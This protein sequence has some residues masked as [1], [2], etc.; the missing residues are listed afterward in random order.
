MRQVIEEIR[1]GNFN[2]D[3][4]SLDFSCPR[5]EMSLLA[6]TVEEGSFSVYGPEG[7]VTEG[8][9]VS[10]DLRMECMTQNFSGSED[11][12]LYRFDARGMEE[13]E[14]VK[15]AF[16]VISNQGEYYLPFSVVIEPKIITSSLGNIKNLFHFTN[17]AKSNWEEAVKLFYSKEFGAVFNG[18]DKQYY[19]A[20][21]GLSSSYGNEHNVEEFL[22]E[23]RKK[24]PVEYIPEETQIKIEDPL[25]MTRYALVI[26]RNG[27]GYTHLQIRT[28]GEFLQIEEDTVTDS[29]FLGNIYRLYYYVNHEK[30]HA[31]NNYGAIV[32]E[33]EHETIRIPV[34]VVQH[35]TARKTLGLHREKMRQTVSL[36]EYY[37]AFRLKKISTK[38]WLAETHKLLNRMSEM[39]DRDIAVKL[40]R[41]Q[42]LLTEERDNEAKWLIE[43]QEEQ[44][45]SMQEENPE[46]WCYYLYLTT[47]YSKDDQ[48]V[49]DVAAL[50]E[51]FYNRNR[52]NWRIAWLLMYLSEEY[53]K[54][55]S[56]KWLLLEELFQ[57][58]CSSPVI[59]IEAWHILCM[60]PAMLMKL[61]TFELQILLYAVKNDLMKDEIVL[62]IVYLAQKQKSF[63]DHLFRILKGC[64]EKKP[65]NDILHAICTLL[66]KGNCQGEEYFPWY[67]A[68]VEQNLRITRLYEYYMMSISLPYDG[69]LP[70]MILMY[71]AY[72][73]DL[74]YEITAY[75]Y[76]YVY[77]H[78]EEIPDIYVNYCAAM[79]RFVLEQIQRGRI[80]KD[81]AYLYRN[82]ISLPMIDEETAKQL[83]SLLFMQEIRVLSDKITEVILVYPYGVGQTVYPVVSGKAMVPVY[84]SDCKILLGDGE[85][86]RYT[87]SVEYQTEAM[88]C[89]AKLALMIAP[90]VRD[91]LGYAIYTCCEYQNRFEVQEDNADLFV[92]LAE[93]DKIEDNMKREIRMMLVDFYFEKDRMRELDDYL[94]SLK[95]EDVAHRDRKKIIRYMVA[96]AMYEE[97]Y[98]WIRCLGPYQVDAKVLLKLCSRLLD[99]EEREEDP[100]MTGI[101]FYILQ[102]GKYDENIL[103]YLVRYYSGSIKDM[104]DIWKAAESYGVDTYSLSERMLVQ[105]LYTGSHVG[106]KSDIFRSYRKNGGSEEL[107]AAFL[108]K[109]CYD[110]AV[111]GQITESYIFESVLELCQRQVPLHLV[112]KIAFLQYYAENKQEQTEKSRQVC[113][114]FLK[115]LLAE[116]IVL[117]IYKEYQ[118]YVP[119]MDEYM[120]KT[121]VEYRAKPGNKAVIHYVIQSEGGA[122]NEYCKEEMKDMFAGICVKEFILFFGER[123]QFYITEETDGNEQLTKSGTINK[124]DAGE[125]NYGSRFSML[126]DIMIGKNLQ[127]YDTVN[128]LLHEYYKQDFMVDKIF[129]LK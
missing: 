44:V 17:L 8:Y 129:R 7:R 1:N 2:F 35:V 47:L 57:Y 126:N 97:A 105:M 113:C 53:V 59:Y 99:M 127:D 13:G 103:K 72:Q 96:R 109:C 75:L 98:G 69:P 73:S 111:G 60:N 104:R 18:S 67:R 16:H 117:P 66:I 95:P 81:L 93:S 49:D 52:G 26:N 58:H 22:L 34:T 124:S 24:K 125:E 37:Q 65:Q 33:K 89:P 27:W 10:S 30:L 110:Y 112:C 29:A 115:D 63:S 70:K 32:L 87:V 120:D 92:Y 78:R 12:I 11:Q 54:S 41:A 68:G 101:F 50:V 21:K 80:N 76:A 38:T 122:E 6:G 88:I 82:L 83:A 3:N 39:D 55:P 45:L 62:Q 123:L 56:R 15:G 48:Y 128:H 40:F 116:N 19:A 90:F 31:G 4:G 94:L 74:R 84:D 86:N 23:I 79:E 114:R 28:E 20:Y 71:F 64:Y 9:V 121:M 14:E 36:M 91:H 106:E 46:L 25:E 100:I 61:G 108:S 118:G 85:G 102:K 77:K 43:K 42:I 107:M 51:D 5:I 119:Q